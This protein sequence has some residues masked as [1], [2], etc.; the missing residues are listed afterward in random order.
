[1][2]EPPPNTAPQPEPVPQT[3]AAA[4][5]PAAA[6]TSAPHGIWV[7]LKEHKVMQWTLAYAAAAYTLLH[8]VEMLS[9][10]Q[11]WPHTIVRV[12]SLLLVIGVPVVM[13]L[14]WYHGARAQR[15][16]SGS[17]LTIITLLLMIGG[18]TL[19]AIGRTHGEAAHAGTP[20][21]ASGGA[22]PTPNEKSIAVLPF[23]DMS[24]AGDQEYFADGM[25]EEV[26]DMLS[27]IPALKV[28]AR[29]S[30]FQFKGKATDVRSVAQQ[31]GVA[32]VLEGSVRK[33]GKRLRIT[34]QL[35][36]AADGS[37]LWSESYDR[38][39]D[40]V[41]RIQDEIAGAIVKHLQLSLLDSGARG[42][43]PTSNPEA[44]ALYLQARYLADRDTVESLDQALPLYQQAI[45]LDP[46]YAAAYAHMAYCY[47][48]RVANGIDTD[49]AGY[50]N[51]RSAAARA[52]VLDPKL[53]EG[54]LA[55]GVA[56]L[57]Y[58]LNWPAAAAL[59]EKARALDPN[60]ALMF[61]L[62]GHLT[63]A[64]GSLQ[65][66]I[67]NFRQ[68]VEHDPLNRLMGRYLSSMLY[69]AGEYSEAQRVLRGVIEADPAFPAI[70]YELG[71]VMLALGNPQA[72]VA[73]FKAE[74]SLTWRQIGMPLAY[75]ALGRSADAGA[76][77]AELVANSSGS[78]FQVAEAYAYFGDPD[79]AFRWLERAHSLHDPGLMKIRHD[80]LLKSLE[81]DPRYVP[82]L[83]S[84]HLT[85]A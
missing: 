52:I 17:E 60:N 16:V 23:T 59:I 71:R 7:R 80:P 43:T 21:A 73:A 26:L 15:H 78:E 41:F 81:H 77:L 68:A 66:S 18:A 46:N 35:I 1:M 29:T 39:V 51:A 5:T 79:Q 70:H 38:Q 25:A 53:P 57:Q 65:E 24:E 85:P 14:A 42:V 62:S 50:A 10:A 45:A 22:V 49:G 9:E 69:Y 4:A 34:T 2:D 48:R 47:G 20:A 33:A 83:A 3:R 63:V 28:I 37:H 72:A 8:G 27:R 82:F 74:P 44:H 36:R 40:D 31:L 58:E 61:E 12:V 84:M 55:L 67:A 19:W 54:Y 30:S 75:H 6:P 11:D 32:T 76:A 13:T 56:R 64:T